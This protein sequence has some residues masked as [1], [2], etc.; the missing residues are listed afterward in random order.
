MALVLKKENIIPANF[1]ETELTIN[2]LIE[3]QRQKSKKSKK[4]KS[5][6]CSRKSSSLK[7]STGSGTMATSR[8]I[9]E[10]QNYI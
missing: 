7:K 9:I 1:K 5:H 2:K 3:D 4:R 8:H 10:L 6:S